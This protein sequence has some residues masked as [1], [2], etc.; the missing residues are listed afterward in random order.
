MLNYRIE[1]LFIA[2]RMI[3]YFKRTCVGSIVPT[4]EPSYL[5]KA[6][7]VMEWNINMYIAYR[8]CVRVGFSLYEY[9]FCYEYETVLS[10]LLVLQTLARDSLHNPFTIHIQKILSLLVE[11]VCNALHV[12][13]NMLH[14]LKILL[15]KLRW[16]QAI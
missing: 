16:N 5:S 12:W 4:A 11:V 2:L 7:T 1:Y 10:H 6:K 13:T 15:Y 8:D 3:P 9:W 14:T